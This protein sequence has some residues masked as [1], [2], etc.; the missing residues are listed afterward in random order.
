MADNGPGLSEPEQKKIFER[1]FRADSSRLRNA[2]E[3]S[4]L[5]LSIVDAVIDPHRGKLGVVSQPGHG[6][7][8]TPFFPNTKI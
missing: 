1:F 5:G 8:F 2:N 3:G 7:V 6:T 4:G